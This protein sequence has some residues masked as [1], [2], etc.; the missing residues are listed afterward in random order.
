[1]FGSENRYGVW[2]LQAL[3]SLGTTVLV[4]RLGSE[5][6]FTRA[7]LWAAGLTCFYPSWLGYT[8]LLLSETLFTFLSLR[9]LPGVCAGI[10]ARLARRGGVLR[11]T[12]WLGRADPQRRL[13]LPAGA[14]HVHA[15]RVAR[16]FWPAVGGGRF[17]GHRVFAT[18]APGASATRGFKER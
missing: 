1:M 17:A 3:L 7:G 16:K 9:R 13:A 8:F 14:G 10:A 5:L 4:Y 18:L 12:D 2:G 15:R 6:F 11:L